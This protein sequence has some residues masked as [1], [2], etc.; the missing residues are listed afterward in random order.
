MAT[1]KI[2]VRYERADGLYPVYIRVT[3]NRKSRFINT[4][5]VTS[6]KYI[7]S[8]TKEIKDPFVMQVCSAK[9]SKFAELLNKTDIRKWDIEMVVNYLQKTTDDVCFS[10]FAREYHDEMY[11]DG[12]ARNAR[13]YELAY[14]H[15]ERFAGTNKIMFSQ[16]TSSFIANWIDSLKKTARAK[17]MYPVC[18]RQIFKKALLKYNDYDAGI[19]R[20]TT[21]P[22]PKITIPRCDAPQ[23]RAITMEACREFFNAPLPESDRKVPLSQ[24]GRDVA[25]MCIC[26]AGINT[27]DIFEMKKENYHD[28]ILFYERAKTRAARADN[29]YMEMKV[30][31]ILNDIFDRYLDKTPSPYLFN[32]HERMS[33]SDSFGANVNMGIRQICEKS[34]GIPH[35]KTYCVYTFRHTW[36]TV[37][38]N[39]CGATISEVGF[40]MNHTD[41][42]R[43]TRGY[44]KIDFTPA[45]ELNQKVIDK[46]FFTEN[47]SREYINQEKVFLERFSKYQ[48]MRG[49]LFFKGKPLAEIEDIGFTNIDQII[50]ALMKKVP[51]DLPNR[52]LVLIR[53]ENVDKGQT[54]EY[55]RMINR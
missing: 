52:V 39:E 20:I 27:V 10:D 8:K 37:A 15:L 31:S 45:W 28:G 33:N 9:I 43:V 50:D 35:D 34:L 18:I 14:Q 5:K 36:A 46:I 44:I 7:N 29:A 4:G 54:Q 19:L 11:N 6:K 22:W 47:K 30:P 38:Q 40:A 1:F 32:F 53:I 3:H 25:M 21:N 48:L 51:D 55:S 24:I 17:E 2:T 12:H 49:T 41:R 42:Q 13:N 16:L 23:K 26:L